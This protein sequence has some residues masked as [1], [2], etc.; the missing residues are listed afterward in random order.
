M[1]N[2]GFEFLS[3]EENLKNKSTQIINVSRP[4]SILESVKDFFYIKSEEPEAKLNITKFGSF[5]ANFKELPPPLPKEYWATLFGVIVTA[6]ISSWLTPTIIGWRK[7]KKHQDKLNDYQNE[8]KDLYKDSKL[9]KKNISK[10]DNL[11]EKV[12]S[13]YTKGDLTKEQYDVLLKNISVKYNEIFQNEIDL[14]K[15]RIDKED[16]IKLINELDTKLDNAYLQ[17][18]MSKE[19]YTLLKEKISEMANKK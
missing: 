3:W 7:S 1:P 5:I 16:K 8:L 18:K 14:L 9:D 17:E 10:L 13:G 4:A 6:F 15:N 11:R 12:V 2:K 19:H